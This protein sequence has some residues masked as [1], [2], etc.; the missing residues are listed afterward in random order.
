MSPDNLLRM[1]NQIATFYESQPEAVQVTGVAQHIND[2]WDP[3]M[4]GQ[5]AVMLASDPTPFHALVRAAAPQLRPVGT[6]PERNNA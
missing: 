3:R 6:S 2:F 4:R 1:A 5:L